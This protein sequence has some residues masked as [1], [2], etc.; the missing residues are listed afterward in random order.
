MNERQD[1]KPVGQK[2]I[3]W[4]IGIAAALRLLPLARLHPIVW[5]EVEFYRATDFVSRGLVPYRDFWEH[6]TPLQ[7][8]LFAPIAMLVKSPGVST[9]LIMRWAQLPLWI[10]TFVLLWKWMRG[11]GF[12]AT[13]TALSMLFAVCSTQFALGA[14]EYRVDALGCTL[15][16]AGLLLLQR[17][18]GYWAGAMFCLAG[19]ANIRLGP[20]LVLTIL[21]SRL[22]WRAIAGAAV[23]LAACV[24]Y[25]LVTHSAVLAWRDNWTD[26]YIADRIQTGP[27]GAFFY[28]FTNVFGFLTRGFDPGAIDVGSIVV[29]LAAACGMIWILATRWRRRDT[30]F[31]LAVLEIANLAF[32]AKMKFIYHYHFLIVTLMA[33]PFVALVFDWLL[34]RGHRA[35]IAAVVAASVAVSAFA[36]VFR[37]K[38]D[39][40]AYQDF[41]MHEVDRIVP[42]HGRV[43]GGVGYAIRKEPAYRYWFLP[44]IVQV[45]EARGRF[46]RY[47]I[48]ANPPDAVILDI[49]TRLWFTNR[50][51]QAAFVRRHYLPTLPELWVPGMSAQLTRE[52]PSAQWI[53]PADGTYIVHAPLPLRVTIDGVMQP[54]SAR[55]ALRKRQRLEFAADVTQP[56]TVIVIP[57]GGPPLFRR[58]PPG[59]TLDANAPPRTHWPRLW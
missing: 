20:L 21:L 17:G 32:I 1:Q 11:E 52:H 28:R 5:D 47:D 42:P 15:F 59:L 30:L 57:A 2:L 53:V 29:M 27:P 50:P 33:L 31:V 18:R 56:V 43:F 24:S 3:G 37:G 7:W 26:N 6:H 23:A 58:P 48:T 35:V 49:P 45:L 12:S 41:F 8:F 39:E 54:P 44:N 40:L 19:F 10:L 34:A 38:E 9:I 51:A 46:E 14:I 55:L 16:M 36:S 4:L 25:F 13:S 22:R